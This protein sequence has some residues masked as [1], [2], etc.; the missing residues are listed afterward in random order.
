MLR[1]ASSHSW[2]TDRGVKI[3]RHPRHFSMNGGTQSEKR[4]LYLLCWASPMSRPI[5]KVFT[6]LNRAFAAGRC[7]DEWVSLS[8]LTKRK[9]RFCPFKANLINKGVEPVRMLLPMTTAARHFIVLFITSDD[10]L[11]RALESGIKFYYGFPDRSLPTDEEKRLIWSPRCKVRCSRKWWRKQRT[12]VHLIDAEPLRPPN[13]HCRAREQESSSIRL[14]VLSI[15]WIIIQ[16]TKEST[17]IESIAFLFASMNANER[18]SLISWIFRA[19]P[20]SS[21]D[22]SKQF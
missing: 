22:R 14:S 9:S 4:R 15:Y 19:F 3:V 8:W 2:F 10:S 21:D 11:R 7:D 5:N 13:A 20:L 6:S 17:L 12:E 16:N 18:R 1:K